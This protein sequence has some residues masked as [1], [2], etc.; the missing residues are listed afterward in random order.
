MANVIVDGLMANY[1]KI[2][3][4]KKVLVFLHGWAD[5]SKTFAGLMP[6]LKD[7]YTVLAL[8]LPG[9]GASQKP[10]SAWSTNDF[11]QFV[12][13][14][15]AKLQIKNIEAFVTHSFGGSVAINGLAN[16][17]IK[18]DKLVL[19][20][21][22]GVRDGNPAKKLILAVMAKV[23]RLLLYLLPKSQRQKVRARVYGKLGSDLVVLGSMEPTFRRIINEDMQDNASKIKARTLL[24]YGADDDQT[25]LADGKLFNRAIAGSQL[26]IIEGAGHFVHQERAEQVAEMIKDF[27]KDGHD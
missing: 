5:G 22:A 15:L 26:E 2:G 27:L 13:D 1:Q 21:S 11:S 20:A 18:A 6:S 14:W 8:D 25:P 17:Q 10:E 4:G 16:G 7:D 9:F 12:A 3:S 23:A 24:I 19:I